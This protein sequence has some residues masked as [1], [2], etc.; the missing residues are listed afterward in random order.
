V[1][2]FDVNRKDMKDDV[3][4]DP[5]NF[6]ETI[7]FAFQCSDPASIGVNVAEIEVVRDDEQTPV[8][9]EP[10]GTVYDVTYKRS[11]NAGEAHILT[12][13]CGDPEPQ[14]DLRKRAA[15]DQ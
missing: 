11:G 5:K 3:V 13:L 8:P 7:Y 9:G 12:F 10:T 1:F 15:S 6:T 14:F 2:G 4:P